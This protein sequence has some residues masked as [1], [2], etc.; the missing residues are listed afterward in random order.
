MAKRIIGVMLIFMV[1]STGLGA[2]G[3]N[4]T[5]MGCRA[6][7]LGAAFAGVA[8]DPSAIFYNPAGLV[9]QERRLNFSINGFSVW[10]SYEFVTPAGYRAES[11]FQSSIPQIFITYKMNE[12][13]TLGFG[14]YVP[15]AGSGVDW[16]SEQLGFPFKSHMAV[17]AFSPTLAY[18]VNEN[19][20]VGFNL[21]FYRGV[22]SVDTLTEEMGPMN[23]DESG[24][25]FSFGAGMARTGHEAKRTTLSATEP[26]T[27]RFQ[28]LCP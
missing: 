10:P 27:K 23:A 9:Y 8:D 6:L 1:L 16:K 15:Y 4:N 20:S 14:A 12:R 18:Q 25:T 13:I 21:H 24:S 2:G 11:K 5:L 28:P 26:K 19:L 22:L 7:A 17:M 3:W